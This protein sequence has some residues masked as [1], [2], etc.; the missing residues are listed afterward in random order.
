[1]CFRIIFAE[2]KDSILAIV[3]PC[4]KEEAVLE[5]TTT[6][7]TELMDSMIN[8]KLISERSF[9]LFVNDGSKDNT[10]PL[11][12]S[13]HEINKHVKGV[14]LACN[15]GHQ[16]ALWAGMSVAVEKSDMIVSID[17]DLQD[18]VNAISKM[19]KKYHEG[20]DVVYGV[21]NERKTDSFF[22]RNTALAFYKLMHIMGAKTVYNHADFRLLSKRALKFLLQFKERNLFIRGL[23]PLLGYKT[24][25]VYYNRAERFAGESKYPLSKMLNFA[26]DGITSFSVKPIRLIMIL[27]VFFIFIAFCV[28]AWILY[29]YFT[30]ITVKGWSSLMLSIWFCSGCVLMGL[31]IVGE[32]IGK[33]YIES[34]QRP[35]Y[36]IEA[37]LMD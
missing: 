7:L 9:I 1:M 22:K 15:V 24:D 19:V 5:E 8:E 18:D 26:I 29:S 23:V 32:Y 28:L 27:G 37:I 25:N 12:V 34:K 13:Y 4:Y 11:I 16:N 30:G 3:V 33:I 35:R 20:C 2:M 31:G 21:R 10:W 6:R 17:A 36:N 14:N